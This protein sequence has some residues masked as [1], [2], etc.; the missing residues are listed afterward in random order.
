MLIY[1]IRHGQKEI[2]PGDPPLTA[3]GYLQ[4]KKTAQALLGQKIQTII[5]SPLKRTFQTAEI[6]A[7]TLN[8][9]M[10]VKTELLERASWEK[11]ISL[12]QFHDIWRQASLDR[13]SQPS[14]GDSSRSVGARIQQMTELLAKQ[15]NLSRVLLVTHGG[16]ITDFLRNLFS[17]EYLIETYFKDEEH[18]LQAAIKECSITIL[19][20]KRGRFE[21]KTLAD[22]THLD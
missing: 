16:V 13:D 17:D 3:I 14:V 7:Q 15:K 8:I 11:S 9:P 2:E 21:L 19:E 5:S 4:A 10:E 20:Y 22:V 1:L 6:I 18:L 12:E